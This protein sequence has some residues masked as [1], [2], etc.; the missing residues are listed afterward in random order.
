MN[1]QQKELV[2]SAAD[3][4]EPLNSSTICFH[5]QKADCRTMS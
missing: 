1:L 2:L 5:S 4:R 3:R